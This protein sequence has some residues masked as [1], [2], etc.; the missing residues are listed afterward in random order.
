MRHHAPS[1][2]HALTLRP[3]AY[4][5]TLRLCDTLRPFT[6]PRARTMHAPAYAH[7]HGYAPAQT[8]TDARAPIP[9]RMA[10]GQTRPPI[11]AQEKENPHNGG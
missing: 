4:R 5:Q 6:R 1:A 11:D 9:A 8:Q 10:H 2:R 3:P 7:A